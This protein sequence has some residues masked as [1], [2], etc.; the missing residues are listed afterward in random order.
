ML[1]SHSLTGKNLGS[2]IKKLKDK[3]KTDDFIKTI[4]IKICHG[5]LF[6]C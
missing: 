5:K 2:H 1:K 3:D 6:N 4:T